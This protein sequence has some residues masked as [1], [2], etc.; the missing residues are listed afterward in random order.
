MLEHRRPRVLHYRPDSTKARS[1]LTDEYD[2]IMVGAG[3]SG[4]VLAERL[5]R[6]AGAKVLL[7]DK[8]NHIGGNCYDYLDPDANV[9]VNKYGAHLFHTDLAHVWMYITSL[10]AWERYDH[11]VLARVDGK[12]VPVP[13]NINTVNSLLNLT[14]KTESEMDAWLKATQVPPSHGGAPR[15]S[16]E[17]ALSR[18]GSALY[19]KVFE[20]YTKKQWAK[21]PSELAPSVTARIPVRNNFDNRYFSDRFQAL[22][23]GGYTSFFQSLLAHPNVTTLLDVD[24]FEV[25]PLLSKRAKLFYTGPVDSYFST[26]GLGKLEYRSIRF[27]RELY[28]NY[29]F[30]QPV[31]VVN[32]PQDEQNCGFDDCS[33]TRI[34]E[35]KHYYGQQS[36]HTVTF[37]EYSSDEGEPYYPVPSERNV[38]L[39]H[40][41]KALAE[42]EKGVYF[43]GRLANYK[44]FN[45]DQAI[46]NALAIFE[47]TLCDIMPA[48]AAC[49]AAKRGEHPS[50]WATKRA[51]VPPGAASAPSVG[52][53]ARGGGGL[54]GSG[55]AQDKALDTAW[56]S[57]SD[58]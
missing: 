11:Q 56:R 39:Y 19:K 33:F 14:L 21:D 26:S 36:P 47:Q 32:Y 23:S 40:K 41:F 13:V 57:P 50:M 5:A 38:Q 3:L 2:V 58:D 12:L 18:V 28:R 10:H 8:R 48:S 22:P 55:G 17:M 31:S 7:L 1:A 49:A 24:F 9:L 34:V 44:Y 51:N 29:G 35:Y 15:N 4:G 16:K 27:V 53:P 43:V 25:R 54:V 30:W 42:A 20:P 37:R 6:L 46:D 45:M 52:V